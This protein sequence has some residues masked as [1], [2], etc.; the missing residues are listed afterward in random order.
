MTDVDIDPLGDHKSRTEEPTG[1]DI[2]LNPVV[3]R[4][5]GDQNVYKKHHLEKKL[6]KGGS[7]ILMSTVCTSSYLGIIS[8][9]L[10]QPI[11]IDL[12]VKVCGFTSKAGRMIHSPMRME[13]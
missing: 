5:V 13:S 6:K 8:E 12:N 9:S 4:Q 2:P 3:E 11:P 1:E 10:M 7:P